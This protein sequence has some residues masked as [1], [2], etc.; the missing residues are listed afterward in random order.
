MY[1]LTGLEAGKSKIKVPE[2]CE[3]LKEDFRYYSHPQ[4]V[5]QM[6]S[7]QVSEY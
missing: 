3:S 7:Q 1:W 5:K 2:S 4:W 6:H